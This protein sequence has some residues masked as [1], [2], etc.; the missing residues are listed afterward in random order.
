MDKTVILA[1][2]SGGYGIAFCR[3]KK[4]NLLRYGFRKVTVVV[5]KNDSKLIDLHGYLQKEEKMIYL[6]ENQYL[7]LFLSSKRL[8]KKAVLD[9]HGDYAKDMRRKTNGNKHTNPAEMRARKYKK[10]WD[11]TNW[12]D[13]Q[14]G[15]GG[16]H[17]IKCGHLAYLGKSYCFHC[18]K[19]Q[20]EAAS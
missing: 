12:G 11:T 3:A 2:K 15:K 18:L 4:K 10:E 16:Q 17:C 6:P 8:V 19:E 13:F 7:Q 5:E 20:M 14:C 9:G 1:P